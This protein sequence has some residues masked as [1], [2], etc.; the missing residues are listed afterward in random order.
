M[1]SKIAT[2]GGGW[3]RALLTA[4]LIKFCGGG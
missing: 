2:G 1:A 4:R 3:R